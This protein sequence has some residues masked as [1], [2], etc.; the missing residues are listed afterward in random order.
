[1]KYHL[2]PRPPQTKALGPLKGSNATSE[3]N[4]NSLRGKISSNNSTELIDGIKGTSTKRGSVE[5]GHPNVF[6]Y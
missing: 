6:A 4:R 2:A 1:M 5:L 3:S